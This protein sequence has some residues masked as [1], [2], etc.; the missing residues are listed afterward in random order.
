MRQAVFV[1]PDPDR[2]YGGSKTREGKKLVL[3]C[4]RLLAPSVADS[5]N[6]SPALVRGSRPPNSVGPPTGDSPSNAGPL[7]ASA[8][9][10][11]AKMAVR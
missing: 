5:L 3:P 1:M 10:L 6:A 7:A 8:D 11:R 9:V 2:D 4:E